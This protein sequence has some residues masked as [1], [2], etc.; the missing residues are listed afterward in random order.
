[1]PEECQQIKNNFAIFCVLLHYI[2]CVSLQGVLFYVPHYLWKIFEDRKLAKITNGLRGRTL[3]IEDR[4]DKCTELVR[5]IS[6][7]FHTHNT[8]AVKYF[9]CD[10][11]NFV[12]VIGQMYLINTFL[13]GVFMTYGKLNGFLRSIVVPLNI[14]GKLPKGWQPNYF[15][16]QLYFQERMSSNGARP[17]LKTELIQ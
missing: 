16:I 12:N 9:L 3:R 7:T 10:I 1:M 17:N 8:Y 4:A 14:I 5:Y 6:E 13:G 2:H 11:L 15:V